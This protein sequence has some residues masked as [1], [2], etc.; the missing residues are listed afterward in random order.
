MDKVLAMGVGEFLRGVVGEFGEDKGGE[1]GGVGG[2]DGGVFGEDR[3]AVGDAGA[4]EKGV[5]V[6]WMVG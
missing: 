4:G 1:L 3:R 5:G 2:G 6:S